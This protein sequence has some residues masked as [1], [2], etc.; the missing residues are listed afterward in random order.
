MFVFRRPVSAV[1]AALM[2]SAMVVVIDV[3]FRAGGA[4]FVGAQN[5]R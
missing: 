2:T 1:F 4:H 5:P 3:I